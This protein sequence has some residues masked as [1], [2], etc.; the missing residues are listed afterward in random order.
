M[1]TLFLT[2]R[3]KALVPTSYCH[4][5]AEWL[6]QLPGR[7]SPLQDLLSGSDFGLQFVCDFWKQVK[8]LVYS[9]A[10]KA[11]LCQQ[12]EGPLMPEKLK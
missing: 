7:A 9:N 6:C 3:E 11:I 8:F 1:Y 12:M 4:P 10:R 5:T 2:T